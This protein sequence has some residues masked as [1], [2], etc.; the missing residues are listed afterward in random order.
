[1]RPTPVPPGSH[2]GRHAVGRAGRPLL[3]VLAVLTACTL[4]ATPASAYWG[5]TGSGTAAA[6][7]G[8]LA[9]PVGVSV[10]TESVQDVTVTWSQGSPGVTPEG[11]YLTRSDSETTSP[12]C[13]SAPTTLVP[14]PSCVDADV[15]PGAYTYTVTAVYRSWSTAGSASATVIVLDPARFAFSARG[16]DPTAP[17]ELA[18]D[19]APSP[20]DAPSVLI[21]PRTTPESMP[22]PE[23]T[24]SGQPAPTPEPTATAEPSP[25]PEP[26]ATVEPTVDPTAD[27]TP[28]PTTDPTPSPTDADLDGTATS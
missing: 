5:A 12:A 27:P 9:A 17:T 4:A 7:T 21:E 25:S 13:G 3:P 16:G 15:P 22:V 20:S 23:P 11:Y 2:R 1:M 14:A 18:D 28:D 6:T 8:T 24:P 19:P 26:T 10:P